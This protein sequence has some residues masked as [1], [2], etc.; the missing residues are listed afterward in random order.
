MKLLAM[1]VG[2]ALPLWVCV[3]QWKP[4]L[5]QKLSP[6]KCLPEALLREM[7]PLH[8]YVFQISENKTTLT[9]PLRFFPEQQLLWSPHSYSP[10][11]KVPVSTHLLTHWEVFT[12]VETIQETFS[13]SNLLTMTHISFFGELHVYGVRLQH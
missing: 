6:V 1:R 10:G 7:L 9:L 2:A 12:A 13:F 4:A 5:P 3:S 8:R 11:C